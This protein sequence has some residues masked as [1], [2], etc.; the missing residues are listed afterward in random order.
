MQAHPGAGLA[1]QQQQQQQQHAIAQ[2][3]L[4][5]HQQSQPAALHSQRVP[6]ASTSADTK[7]G[8]VTTLK[9][10]SDG[11]D[12]YRQAK[13]RKPTALSLPLRFTPN[14]QTRAR[15]PTDLKLAASLDSLDRLSHSYRQLQ[16]VEARLDWTLSRKAIE[17]ADKAR[18]TAD[19]SDRV[20]RT[21]RIHVETRACD[22]DWQI[23]TP[24][25][26]KTAGQVAQDPTTA[27][28]L[29]VPRFQVYLS[30]HVLDDESQTSVPWTQHYQRIT[31]ESSLLSEPITWSRPAPGSSFPARLEFTIPHSS[32]GPTPTLD[33][34]VT[35]HPYSY[36]ST[37]SSQLFTLLPPELSA[38]L[39]VS[40]CTRSEAIHAVWSYV[41]LHRLIVDNVDGR[42]GG[43]IKT[44]EGG[45]S[46][47]FFGGMEK[48]AWHHLGEYA[49][50]WLGPVVPRV[51]E[52]QI[53]IGK[54]SP[55]STHEAYDLPL[56]LFPAAA[57][58]STAQQLRLKTAQLLTS[59]TTAP[60]PSSTPAHP[61]QSTLDSLNS[62]IANSALEVR[63]H[64]TQLDALMAFSRDP[65]SFLETYL[66]SQGHSLDVV[67][68]RN[69]RGDLAGVAG[70]GWK[71]ELRGSKYFGADEGRD[72]WVKE[73]VDVL[74]ARGKEGELLQY[75]RRQMLAQQQQQQQG[76]VRR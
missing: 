28:P 56:S 10:L 74:L 70:H 27:E 8:V 51:I 1:L 5:A 75:R 68:A 29:R 58:S 6:P 43:G 44:H 12:G 4:A 34:K 72:E 64:A 11:D 30:G 21:I 62:Q 37:P 46:K 57:T 50:R 66:S 16:D 20:S 24:D 18:P 2:Q 65:T 31:L 55:V 59:L 19:E 17:L 35:L 38:L 76:V 42:G 14:T 25:E 45:L 54:E 22:Q 73:A 26:L 15:G 3:Q 33:L 69:G 13:R 23:S 71:D 47:K 7:G 61:L 60:A 63:R 53:P 48:I 36:S 67:L 32:S 40:E 49:N 52:S 9:H 39:N 41:R